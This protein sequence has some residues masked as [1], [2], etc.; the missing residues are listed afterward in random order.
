MKFQQLTIAAILGLYA[1]ADP[2]S[3]RADVDGGKGS[4]ALSA[5]DTRQQLGSERRAA[6]ISTAMIT[7]RYNAY[8]ASESADPEWAGARERQ[9]R[10]L[11]ADL[12]GVSVSAIECKSRLCRVRLSFA[13]SDGRRAF[14]DQLAQSP[15]HRALVA[16]SVEEKY[17]GESSSQTMT[18]WISRGGYGL[19]GL[20]GTPPAQIVIDKSGLSG[21]GD[22]G[23]PRR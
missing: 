10:D 19:P 12:N 13:G 15:K 11:T 16:D 21:T 22:S 8:L 18:W 23:V 9:I 17:I 4:E 5:N 6:P 2:R 3:Q 14:H 1:C 20:D 7:E